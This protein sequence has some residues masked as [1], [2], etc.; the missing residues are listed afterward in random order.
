MGK[1][2][3]KPVY[4]R[5]YLYILGKAKGVAKGERFTYV[6]TAFAAIKGHLRWQK[7]ANQGRPLYN[8]PPLHA[9]NHIVVINEDDLPTHQA[10]KIAIKK[11]LQLATE[12]F[13]ICQRGKT[14]YA[15]KKP[16]NLRWWLE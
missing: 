11:L 7:G 8:G 2:E 13:E 1:Q 6:S 5:L 16:K 12:V 10:R 3:K 4:P 9:G 15:R 14:R